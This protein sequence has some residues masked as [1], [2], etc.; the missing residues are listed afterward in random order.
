M[1]KV[2]LKVLA[3]LVPN[4]C[5]FY[6]YAWSA[7]Q[8]LPE[9]REAFG[10]SDLYLDIKYHG[11]PKRSIK[12]PDPETVEFDGVLATDTAENQVKG[13]RFR[14]NGDT[15]YT[16]YLGEKKF[17]GWLVPGSKGCEPQLNYQLEQEGKVVQKGTM[18]AGFCS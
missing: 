7:F 18:K 17:L 9:H 12:S 13:R 5:L 10:A 4:F 8:T 14:V 6:A 1:S 11:Y 2:Q 15:W 16:F 3:L